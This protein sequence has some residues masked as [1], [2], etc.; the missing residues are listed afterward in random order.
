MR[1]A[2][3]DGYWKKISKQKSYSNYIKNITFVGCNGLDGTISIE[4][5]ITVFCGL[6]GVGKS[7]IIASIKELLG[8]TDDSVVSKNKFHGKVSATIQINKTDFEISDK[9]TAFDQGLDQNLV[10]YIDSDQAMNCLKFWD[11]SNLDEL[12]EGEEEN[13]F[14]S[15]QIDE[16][17]F[18]IGK[19][20]SRCSSYELSDEEVYYKPVFFNVSVGEISYNS[21]SMGVGEH[22][23]F[24][25]YY[26]LENIPE[27]S[28]VIIEEPETF[29][30]VLSQIH[31]IQYVLKVISQKRISVIISTHSPHIARNIRH[32]N[33]R[34]IVKIEDY[35]R[36]HK[37]SATEEIPA[38]LGVEY[39]KIVSCD[40]KT[41]TIFVEDYAA[42]IFLECILK[43]ELPY[44]YKKVD[45]VSVNGEAEITNRLSF[46]DKEYMSHKFIG[47]YDGDM[48][49]KFEKDKIIEKIY[50]QHLFL[51]LEECI[52]KEMIHFLRDGDKMLS[53]CS[54]LNI[55][56]DFGLSIFSKYIGEDHH[57][58]FLN[59]SRDLS[60]TNIEFMEA[61]YHIWKQSNNDNIRAF[62]E[63]LQTAV[64]S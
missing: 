32:D 8:F 24:Y 42:R 62:T 15:K 13:E 50:W 29:I 17:S 9:S 63:S 34:S 40:C 51:P 53:L 43:T 4:P 47:I 44:I 18:L 41:A 58:W 12:F 22:F 28:I 25:L 46:N 57:D 1:S 48:K 39:N 23:I 36:I 19:T 54:Q 30:S 61:F 35:F 6:N 59:V 52:E 26:T 11:Q 49:E 56:P 5:G 45:I 60:K 55:S 20:Y 31:L 21:V 16:L 27:D 64:K 10:K 33:I 37:P 3:V 2:S 7:S 14:S 38:F